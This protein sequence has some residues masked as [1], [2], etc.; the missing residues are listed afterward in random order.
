MFNLHRLTTV[1]CH[2]L[3]YAVRD[4]CG[5][6]W[7]YSSPPWFALIVAVPREPTETT[8]SEVTVE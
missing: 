7:K 1:V 6:G 2:P 5:A 3:T 8:P 4:T